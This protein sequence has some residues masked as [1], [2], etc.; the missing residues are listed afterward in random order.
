MTVS[1]RS[2]TRKV[3][4][5]DQIHDNTS[6]EVISITTDKLRLALI[7]HLDCVE[8]KDSWHMPLSF[9]VVVLV[10]FCSSNFK[11]A[12]G[13]SADTWQ[14]LFI[15]FGLGCLFWFIRNLIR[16]RKSPTLEELIQI[17]KNKQE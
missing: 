3:V 15:M 9:L 4:S 12:L 1:P 7:F 5:V 8:K 11:M 2:S 13:L 14:A 17:I 10:V 6:Q 16:L